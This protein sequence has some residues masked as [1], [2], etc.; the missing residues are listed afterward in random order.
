MYHI[1][2]AQGRDLAAVAI[3][4]PPSTF[5]NA[6]TVIRLHNNIRNN[7]FDDAHKT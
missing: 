4:S 1:T 5:C 2:S 6:A 3:N 7:G